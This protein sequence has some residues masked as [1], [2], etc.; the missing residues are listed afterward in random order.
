KRSTVSVTALRRGKSLVFGKDAAQREVRPQLDSHRRVV[1]V[2]LGQEVDGMLEL[3]NR[4]DE[5]RPPGR[6]LRRRGEILRRAT[7]VAAELEMLRENLGLRFP[8]IRKIR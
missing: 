3:R 2:A 7:Q 1:V 4:L 5:P 6:Q 8:D